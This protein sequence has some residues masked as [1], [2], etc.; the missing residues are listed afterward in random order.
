MVEQG[1]DME[2]S[3]LYQDN[4]SAI[5][6]ETNGRASSS[7]RTKHIKVK[8]YLIKDKVDRGEITNEHCPTE[9]M[10]TDINTKPKKGAVFWAFRGHVMGITADNNDA[11][12]VT[13]CNFR[14]PNWVPEPLSMLPI[15]RDRVA[16]KECVGERATNK[17]VGLGSESP[18]KD[19]RVWFAVDEEVPEP[20]AEPIKQDQRAPIKM[21]S[22]HAWSPGIYQALRLPGKSLDVAW[23]R[24]FIH[25]LTLT[26]N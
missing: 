5:L 20:T 12:F 17:E 16:S 14:P 9:Q 24:A 3:L 2:P 26:F 1:Y 22:G 25:P 19:R 10:W 21:V 4:M 7:K 13:R 11:S 18:T 15:S 8:Y 23:E 6:L